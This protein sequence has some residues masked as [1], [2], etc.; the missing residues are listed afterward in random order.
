MIRPPHSATLP[1]AA[2]AGLAMSLVALAGCDQTSPGPTQAVELR[3]A[4]SGTAPGDVAA[5]LVAGRLT[6][7]SFRLMVSEAELG[8]ENEDVDDGD[9]ESELGGDILNVPLDGSAV[10]LETEQVPVG[11]YTEV[12]MEVTRPPAAVLS[13]NPDWPARATMEIRG[14]LDGRAFTLPLEIAGEFTERLPAPVVVDTGGVQPI[15]VVVTL[16][17]AS[18][19]AGPSGLLDPADPAQRA[20][21]E[22]NARAH[23]AE[24]D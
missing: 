12:E 4:A 7:T 16:P 3:L 14:D 15:Q 21:I 24:D 5:R 10:T 6:L 23:I 9:D 20:V 18:W 19:F 2:A 8:P 11:T 17:V 13:Q 1:V 22:Q